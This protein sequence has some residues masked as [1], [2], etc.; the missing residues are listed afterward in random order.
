MG[1]GAAIRIS[2]GSHQVNAVSVYNHFPV[3]KRNLIQ[4]ASLYATNLTDLR[5]PVCTLLYKYI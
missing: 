5:G 4:A 3:E 1:E 2:N